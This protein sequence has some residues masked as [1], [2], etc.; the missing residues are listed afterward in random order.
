MLDVL[1]LL[2]FL[3]ISL[4]FVGCLESF[5]GRGGG[6]RDC[7]GLAVFC[8]CWCCGL[9][10]RDGWSGGGGALAACQAWSAHRDGGGAALKAY[11]HVEPSIAARLGLWSLATWSINSVTV[12]R[13]Y[14]RSTSSHSDAAVVWWS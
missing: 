10:W 1:T 11:S 6:G 2:L 7:M 4:P 3:G 12:Y 9:S 13:C 14:W 5:K 8:W